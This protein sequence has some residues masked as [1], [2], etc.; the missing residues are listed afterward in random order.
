MYFK[1]VLFSRILQVK[2]VIILFGVCVNLPFCYVM[3][4]MGILEANLA[5][6]F[7]F[8]GAWKLR[9]HANWGDG[10]GSGDELVLVRDGKFS[11]GR[12]D[13]LLPIV[14]SSSANIDPD[15]FSLLCFV[16]I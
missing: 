12:G 7:W 9:V 2:E 11:T 16:L 6:S 10:V 1:R 5:E 13:A 14:F 8:A 4:K 3:R 15:A